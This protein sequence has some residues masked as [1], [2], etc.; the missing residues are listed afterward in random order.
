MIDRVRLYLE[1]NFDIE[2]PSQCGYPGL[3]TLCEDARTEKLLYQECLQIL[4]GKDSSNQKFLLS[5]IKLFFGAN[6]NSKVR[7]NESVVTLANYWFVNSCF[8]HIAIEDQ[9]NE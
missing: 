8:K 9:A 3:K 6:E 5:I 2:K 1:A 7:Q 4:T